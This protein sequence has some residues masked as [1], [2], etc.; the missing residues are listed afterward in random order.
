MSF[1][2]RTINNDKSILSVE[3]STG[4]M[5]GS[6]S[7]EYHY[8]S[9]IGE[10]QLLECNSCGH[11]ISQECLQLTNT[12]SENQSC[13]KCNDKDLKNNLGLEVRLKK[14]VKFKLFNFNGNFIY[15]R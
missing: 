8:L 15:Y 4:I 11:R 6:M 12:D 1:F 3:G 9:S 13:P 14:M 5:G 2:Q 7:H 10:D